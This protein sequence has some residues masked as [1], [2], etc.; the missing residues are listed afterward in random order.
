MREFGTRLVDDGFSFTP[1]TNTP[2]YYVNSEG[3][4]TLDYLFFNPGVRV[5]SVVTHVR[6][7]ISHAAVSAQ[8]SIPFPPKGNFEVMWMALWSTL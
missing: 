2:T 7:K 3:I 8:V 6:P 1:V 4:S 5:R